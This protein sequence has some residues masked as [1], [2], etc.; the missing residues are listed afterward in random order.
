[1]HGVG[2]SYAALRRPAVCFLTNGRAKR[3][4]QCR[5]QDETAN[6]G[7]AQFAVV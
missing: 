1:M 5:S 6:G 7:I 4:E 3:A 2:L